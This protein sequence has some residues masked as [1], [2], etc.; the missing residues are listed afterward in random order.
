M[1]EGE[2]VAKQQANPA[3]PSESQAGGQNVCE[4][5][6]GGQESGEPPGVTLQSLPYELIMQIASRVC[7]GCEHGIGARGGLRWWGEGAEG[8][9]ARAGS[10]CVAGKMP[11][12][13]HADGLQQSHHTMPLQH[14][15]RSALAHTPRH[16]QSHNSH[17]LRHSHS[18]ILALALS[19][20]ALA[21][22]A[23][24]VLNSTAAPHCFANLQAFLKAAN[25]TNSVATADTPPR[26]SPTPRSATALSI[27]L[28]ALEAWCFA[29]SHLSLILRSLANLRRLELNS[30]PC[31][32]LSG[33]LIAPSAQQIERPVA[34]SAVNCDT[35]TKSRTLLDSTNLPTHVVSPPLP[36]I[37]VYPPLTHLHISSSSHRHIRLDAIHTALRAVSPT[38]VSL[39][40]DRFRNLDLVDDVRPQLERI[41][42]QHH[43]AHASEPYPITVMTRSDSAYGS[44]DEGEHKTAQSPSSTTT[45]LPSRSTHLPPPLLPP[46]P[47]LKY[48]SLSH[49]PALSSNELVL[50]LLVHCP[51]LTHLNLSGGGMLTDAGVK[52]MIEG[53]K[54]K[55]EGTIN[56]KGLEWVGLKGCD[57]LGPSTLALLCSTFHSSLRHLDMEGTA[58]DSPSLHALTH[59]PLPNLVSL[60]LASIPRLDNVSLASLSVLPSLE[61]LDVAWCPGWGDEVMRDWGKGGQTKLVDVDVTGT[62]VTSKG[63]VAFLRGS[64]SGYGHEQWYERRRRVWI[65]MEE[66]E[67][68]RDRWERV[69]QG[70]TERD[71]LDAVDTLPTSLPPQRTEPPHSSSS[72]NHPT[73]YSALPTVA[74]PVPVAVPTVMSQRELL[75]SQ[76]VVSAPPPANASS[77]PSLT[78]SSAS[79]SEPSFNPN[80]IQYTPSQ[81]LN[82]SSPAIPL[83]SLYLAQRASRPRHSPVAMSAESDV[84]VAR[85][86][87]D[88][89]GDGEEESVEQGDE[90]HD[91]SWYGGA[92][93]GV[94]DGERYDFDGWAMAA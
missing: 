92:G 23:L 83:L 22:A 32:D 66:A 30:V 11:G 89:G 50:Y 38:L 88:G 79:L 93:Y 35:M 58:L 7:G 45:N 36:P 71:R 70:L 82:P 14:T 85:I 29:D 61:I 81:T 76:P 13:L 5:H 62:G 31:I 64:A 24:A 68:A 9:R 18:S 87:A 16:T 37:P 20:R 80:P 3:G 10:A 94:G 73:I 84:G 47:H 78:S 21:P 27:S 19:C 48:L 60:S 90:E 46:L 41:A 67:R 33:F 2:T 63:V 6:K 51:L 56:C 17:F 40:L 39:S 55:T 77:P 8:I 1:A 57:R 28:S 75:E 15:T 25:S 59:P 65:G 49:S 86:G 34:I 44:G 4:S 43:Q 52:R 54:T 53:W 69:E 12:R 26:F 42:Q 74:A 72:L 91:L